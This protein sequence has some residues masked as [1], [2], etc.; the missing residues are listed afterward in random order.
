MMSILATLLAALIVAI[1]LWM[2]NNIRVG[3]SSGTLRHSNTTSTLQRSRQPLKFWSVAAIQ[4][5]IASLFV[6]YGLSRIIIAIA[7]WSH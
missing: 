4:L 7:S 5:V 2:L 3:I 1:G 6:G